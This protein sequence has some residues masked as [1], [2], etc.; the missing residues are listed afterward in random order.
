M[1]VCIHRE[2]ENCFGLINRERERRGDCCF[3][4]AKKNWSNLSLW[5][6]HNTSQYNNNEFVVAISKKQQKPK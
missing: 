4:I 6:L 2:R 1:R 3:F 5:L